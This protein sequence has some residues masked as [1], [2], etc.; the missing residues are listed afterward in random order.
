[1]QSDFNNIKS[2]AGILVSQ[3]TGSSVPLFNNQHYR[4]S[5]AA[6][7]PL[8]R[9]QIYHIVS[10]GGE[11]KAN[12][13]TSQNID[14]SGLQDV[15]AR[16]GS[17]AFGMLSQFSMEMNN[18]WSLP[19]TPFSIHG[20]FIWWE[21]CL[22]VFPWYNSLEIISSVQC[23]PQSWRFPCC[24]TLYSP[25]RCVLRREDS[26]KGSPVLGGQ[27]R[28]TSQNHRHSCTTRQRNAIR[29]NIK[30]PWQS[31]SLWILTPFAIGTRAKAQLISI[32]P[33][34]LLS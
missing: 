6:A 24:P 22:H 31:Q 27:T 32:F 33:F 7:G 30:A 20:K 12:K 29:M 28:I 3:G 18:L 21:W 2:T 9:W 23:F 25:V 11:I 13:E 34:V 16:A 19:S 5:N 26:R 14:F 8:K 4:H 1:M 10:G 17:V 15:S